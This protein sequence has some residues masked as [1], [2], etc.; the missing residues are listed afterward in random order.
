[1]NTEKLINCTATHIKTRVRML[2][3]LMKMA[4]LETM[5][6]Q[7]SFYIIMNIKML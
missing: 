3:E 7:M 5:D 6:K 1:M 2:V 4:S